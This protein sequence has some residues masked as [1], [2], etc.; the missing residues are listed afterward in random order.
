MKKVKIKPVPET[1]M[2]EDK[3]IAGELRDTVIL[4]ALRNGE[5]VEVDFSA[6]ETATQSFVHALLADAIRLKGDD[7]F[8]YLSFRGCAPAVQ[9]IIKTVFGYTLRA[10]ESATGE[11]A[12]IQDAEAERPENTEEFAGLDDDSDPVGS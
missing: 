4:P 7:S 1:S 8:E 10:M 11:S 2:A 12:S 9:S 5:R 6:V 3:D